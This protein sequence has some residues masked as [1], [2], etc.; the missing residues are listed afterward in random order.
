MKENKMGNHFQNIVNQCLLSAARPKNILCK[1]NKCRVVITIKRNNPLEFFK[2]FSFPPPKK[3]IK[4]L[5]I[6]FC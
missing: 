1:F 5:N 4:N 3:K 2:L 6:S